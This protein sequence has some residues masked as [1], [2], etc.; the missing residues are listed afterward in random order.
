[1]LDLIGEDEDLVNG[2]WMS[3]ETHFHISGFVNKQ[4]FRCWSQANPQAPHEKPLHSQK[5]T[6]WCTMSASCTTF[7]RM[8]LVMQLLLMRTAMWKCCKISSPRNSPVFLW[9][10]T[11]YSTRMEQQATQQGCQ[12]RQLMLCSRTESFPGMGISH[13]PRFSNLTPAIIFFGGT[14]K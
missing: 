5:V 8:R 3:D 14:W 9:M 2:I 1:M 6:V 10:K 13:G 12:W 7:L 4:K 11:R